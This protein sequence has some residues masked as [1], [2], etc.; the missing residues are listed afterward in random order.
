MH[1][2]VTRLKE[3]GPLIDYME[4][5]KLLFYLSHCILGFVG[6][7]KL[8][9]MLINTEIL[10]FLPGD[11]PDGQAGHCTQSEWPLQSCSYFA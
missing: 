2:R 6:Y 3:A 9:F 4:R 7:R 8:A 5:I 11:A 1:G 10:S